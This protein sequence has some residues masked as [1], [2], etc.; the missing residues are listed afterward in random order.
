MWLEG[1]KKAT[2]ILDESYL[3]QELR[4]AK[5]ARLSL[6]CYWPSHTYSCRNLLFFSSATKSVERGTLLTSE[7]PP[8]GAVLAR[9]GTKCW[10][11]VKTRLTKVD[12]YTPYS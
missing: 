11:A 1:R 4:L 6:L 10:M 3:S 2:V 8:L 7:F 12:S 5:G 9:P